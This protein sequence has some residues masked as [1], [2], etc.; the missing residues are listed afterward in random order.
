VLVF[1]AF[2]SEGKHFI[3]NLLNRYLLNLSIANHIDWNY[4]T[5]GVRMRG[6]KGE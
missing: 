5:E 1:W 2:T 3:T 4:L 6:E